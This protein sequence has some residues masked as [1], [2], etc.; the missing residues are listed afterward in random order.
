M[1]I[2]ISDRF[3]DGLPFA[4]STWNFYVMLFKWISFGFTLLSTGFFHFWLI[5]PCFFLRSVHLLVPGC[6]LVPVLFFC[7]PLNL[8]RFQSPER[9]VLSL[10]VAWFFLAGVTFHSCGD[11]F[12][13]SMFPFG[14]LLNS[15]CFLW[16]F[17][18]YRVVLC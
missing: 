8:L 5:F 18:Q 2:Y 6:L 1:S 7:F 17:H 3:H 16:I 4:C 15:L 12:D 9:T 10:C 13:L 11:P 14:C